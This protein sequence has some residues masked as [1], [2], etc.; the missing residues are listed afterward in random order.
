MASL[1]ECLFIYVCFK[2]MKAYI[3]S[4]ILFKSYIKGRW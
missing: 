3:Y 2:K 1:Y 4:Y